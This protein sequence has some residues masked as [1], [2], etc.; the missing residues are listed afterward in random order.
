MAW[1]GPATRAVLAAVR[2]PAAAARLHAPRRRVP[3]AF[4]T[5]S[6]PLPSARPLAALMGSPVTVAA[7]MAR[8]TAHPGASAR[9]CCELSQGP[10]F[11]ALLG[12]ALR[13]SASLALAPKSLC[14]LFVTVSNCGGVKNSFGSATTTNELRR[15]L[16]ELRIWGSSAR[17]QGAPPI[18]PFVSRIPGSSFQSLQ[19][20][21]GYLN[22][23]CRSHPFERINDVSFG[24]IKAIMAF[25][26]QQSSKKL[27]NNS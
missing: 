7:V 12:A 16:E 4:A 10:K 25:L 3:P 11:L 17:E 26:P 2:R 20:A 24:G 22:L 23:L 9:A 21:T 27:P 13:F 5:T 1:R 19:F 8:L 18:R 14:I 6:S 15:E